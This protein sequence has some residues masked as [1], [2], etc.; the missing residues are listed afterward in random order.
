MQ[1]RQPTSQ[2]V[3]QPE[4]PV[5]RYSPGDFVQRWVKR[6]LFVKCFVLKIIPST[7]YSYK[8]YDIETQLH[9]VV[10]EQDLQ[11]CEKGWSKLPNVQVLTSANKTTEYPTINFESESTT[12]VAYIDT[13]CG[14]S[15]MTNTFARR[16]MDIKSTNS[17]LYT[18]T[19]MNFAGLNNSSATS[20][21]KISCRL[22]TNFDII[23]ECFVVPD[24]VLPD[25]INLLLGMDILKDSVIDMDKKLLH[26]TPTNAKGVL[27]FNIAMRTIDATFGGMF[28]HQYHVKPVLSINARTVP[29]GQYIVV[30]SKIKDWEEGNK[31]FV[32]GKFFPEYVNTTTKGNKYLDISKAAQEGEVTINGGNLLVLLMNTTK[33]TIFIEPGEP[34]G[35]FQPG[36]ILSKDPKLYTADDYKQAADASELEAISN[37]MNTKKFHDY[38]SGDCSRVAAE[39]VLQ[40][41]K[42]ETEREALI[43]DHNFLSPPTVTVLLTMDT[44]PNFTV[45]CNHRCRVCN[46]LTNQACGRCGR[47]LFCNL[48]CQSLGWP[49][50]ANHCRPPTPFA[51][52]PEMDIDSGDTG[53]YNMP[54][55]DYESKLSEKQL[56]E[57]QEL[58]HHHRKLFSTDPVNPRVVPVPFD[59]SINTGDAVPISVPSRQ[60]TQDKK[61]WLS[62]H[63]AKLLASGCISYSQSPWQFPVHIA[64]K[65][66]P[67]KWRFCVDYKKTK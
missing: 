15:L 19:A 25:G 46:E 57:V 26:W 42:L 67:D 17:K 56:E 38:V 14:V 30:D 62:N 10:R 52:A 50:H 5:A 36:P 40:S 18:V 31:E 23:F 37:D 32:T 16:L 61:V 43:I 9:K 60:T 39:N 21:E 58:L 41:A 3:G 8:V 47:E 28:N 4:I 22:T 63:T 7:F 45:D 33:R 51:P 53:K 49:E 24:P 55:K 20:S 44:A 66:G 2:P 64:N 65:A 13:M 34:L 1:D 12:Y 6:K 27:T 48:H 59:L 54:A 29:P 35:S 11:P